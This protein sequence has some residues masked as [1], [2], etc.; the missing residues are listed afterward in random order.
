MSREFVSGVRGKEFA[1]IEVH[2][3]AESGVDTSI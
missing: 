3:D 2:A 1:G